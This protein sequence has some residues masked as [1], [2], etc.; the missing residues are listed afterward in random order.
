MTN[1]FHQNLLNFTGTNTD[2]NA[3]LARSFEWINRN[4]G[5][6]MAAGFTEIL[7]NGNAVDPMA[8][9]ATTLDPDL[10]RMVVIE[11]G[12]TAAAKFPRTEYIA[13]AWDPDTL[14]IRGGGCVYREQGGYRTDWTTTYIASTDLGTDGHRKITQP[15]ATGG[16]NNAMQIQ[17]RDTRGLAYIVAD[18]SRETYVIGFVHNMYGVGDRTNL[19]ANLGSIADKAIKDAGLTSAN[20]IIGGDFNVLPPTLSSQ[21]GRKSPR[22]YKL[23]TCAALDQNGNYVNTTNSNPYDYW[24]VSETLAKEL[25]LDNDSVSVLAQAR[26]GRLRSQDIFSDH[27]P[28]LLE[29]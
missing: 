25:G 3:A 6:F 13:I 18:W 23:V 28:I 1:F 21:G 2:K 19:R 27:A 16:D 10:T 8:A 26:R 14:R 17:A 11:I 7:N 15:D 9:L 22:G 24:M 4:C 20:V 12:T 5:M 29:F